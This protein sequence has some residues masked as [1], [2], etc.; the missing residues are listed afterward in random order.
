MKKIE[1]Y[2]LYAIDCSGYIVLLYVTNYDEDG[3]PKGISYYK[4]GP[5]LILKNLTDCWYAEHIDRP[6]NKE[7][8]YLF[9]IFHT[10]N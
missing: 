4:Y 8:K 1:P 10:Q 9:S 7:E 3:D 5:N 6:A 2:T